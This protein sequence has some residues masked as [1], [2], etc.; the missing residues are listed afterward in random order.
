MKTRLIKL[1]LL[2][3]LFFLAYQMIYLVFFRIEKKENGSGHPHYKGNAFLYNLF[4]S[5]K[6]IYYHIL[7]WL[8]GHVILSCLR[9]LR[10]AVHLGKVGNS[11]NFSF[12]FLCA[13]SFETSSVL[14]NS[15]LCIY[16][17]TK[18]LSGLNGVRS[19]NFD[20]GSYKSGWEERRVGWNGEWQHSTR[21]Q[22]R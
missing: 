5:V 16:G 17:I 19:E 12:Y 13:S 6:Q 22:D 14:K 1:L 10:V 4:R 9:W 20:H 11:L 7:V 3:S 15:L 2:L 8:F 18:R 21:V